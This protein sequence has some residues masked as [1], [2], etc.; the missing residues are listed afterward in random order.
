MYDGLPTTVVPH[1]GGSHINYLGLRCHISYDISNGPLNIH[2]FSP[3]SYE[4]QKITIPKN[5]RTT[6]NRIGMGLVYSPTWTI[7]FYMI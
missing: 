1:K 2:P 5:K 7:D 6:P 3:I 4:Q